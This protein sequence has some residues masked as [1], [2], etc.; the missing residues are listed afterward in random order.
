MRFP[1][2][3]GTFYDADP[4]KLRANIRRCFLSGRGPGELPGQDNRGSS[5]KIRGLVVPHAGY[6][7]SG[8]IAA[9]AYLELWKDGLPEIIIVIGPNHYSGWPAAALSGENYLTP[10]GEVEVDRHTSKMLEGG[11]IQFDD[12]SQASEHSIEVQLP[13]LQFLSGHFE[14]VPVCMGAQ[15]T[16]TAILLG[17]RIAGILRRKD[18]VIIAS[19]DFSH[20]VPAASAQVKDMKAVK[21][22]LDLDPVRFVKTVTNERITMC[23]YGPVAAMLSAVD[24][25]KGTL[26]AYG[27]SGQV[28][29]MEN[30]VGYGAIKIE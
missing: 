29:P 7:Y 4:A 1:A 15:D 22:I 30:V 25:T 2:V 24:A 17:S 11:Q 14:F 12:I 28:E 18:A 10:F 20:Y 9:H 5:R 16:D 8:E 13:F 3:A 19:S 26:L 23:G 21:S 27:H 6:V